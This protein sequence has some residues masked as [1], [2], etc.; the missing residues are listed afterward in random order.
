[1]MC[2]LAKDDEIHKL[3]AALIA[4]PE[5]VNERDHHGLTALHWAAHLNKPQYVTLLLQHGAEQTATSRDGGTPMMEAVGYGRLRVLK[6]LY[7]HSSGGPG[8]ARMKNYDGYT[9]SSLAREAYLPAAIYLEQKEE[10][11][12]IVSSL[13]DRELRFPIELGDLIKEYYGTKCFVEDW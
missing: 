4:N 8:I 9:A 12:M 10:K 2:E 1:M 5:L 11:A 7:E 6:L 13:I 3:K